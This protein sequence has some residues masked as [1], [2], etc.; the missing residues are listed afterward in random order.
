MNFKQLLLDLPNWLVFAFVVVNMLA[1]GMDLTIRKIVE[2][3]RDIA[4]TARALI[5]SFVL[6]PLTAHFLVKGLHLEH[7]LA[8]GLILMACSAGDPFVTKLSQSAN[9]DKAYSL[10]VMAMLSIVTVVYIPLIV[11]VLLPGTKVD[12]V[13]IA[14][15]LIVLIIVPLVI[16]LVIRARATRFAE[17]WAPHLDRLASILIY[18]AVVLFAVVHYADIAAAFGS[19]AILAAIV[20]VATGAVYG[21]LLGGPSQLHRGDLAVN[22]AWR[23]VSAGM[24]VGIRNFPTEHNV[25]TMAIIIVIVSAV[26]LMPLAATYLRRKNLVA[27]KAAG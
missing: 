19:H 27:S 18:S 6:V 7:G 25:F 17:R 8:L 24:A 23:G 22:T 21:F 26:I 15:P 11:P 14:K 9:G 13:E 2:P 20:M 12:P 16:G 1:L 10:A 3:L 4:L 5:A